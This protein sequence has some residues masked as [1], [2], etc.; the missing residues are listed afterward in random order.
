MVSSG[1]ARTVLG[2]VDVIC[3]SFGNEGLCT[4]GTAKIDTLVTHVTGMSVTIR[5]ERICALRIALKPPIV[6][7]QDKTFTVRYGLRKGL[8]STLRYGIESKDSNIS[9]VFWT[10]K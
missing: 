5:Y 4:D 3:A 7:T 1:F 2:K 9:K 6:D 10:R 8:L